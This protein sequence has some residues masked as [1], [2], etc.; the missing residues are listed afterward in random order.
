MVGIENLVDSLLY[1][2][3]ELVA[4]VSILWKL[5][6]YG[7]RL[8]DL[9]RNSKQNSRENSDEFWKRYRDTKPK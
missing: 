4:I 2:I 7:R 1:N 8:D 9:E 6:S 3:L 5:H